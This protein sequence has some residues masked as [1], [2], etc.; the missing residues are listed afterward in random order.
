MKFLVFIRA[1]ALVP[2]Q[3]CDSV[4]FYFVASM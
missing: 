4:E 2:S 1:N 3:T